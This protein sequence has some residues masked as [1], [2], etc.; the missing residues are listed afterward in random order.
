MEM[1][2]S[3]SDLRFLGL[4]E[5]KTKC[6][7]CNN[8][9][10]KYG[11]I[12]HGEGPV[13]EALFSCIKGVAEPSHRLPEAPAIQNGLSR[14]QLQYLAKYRIV[15]LA[16]DNTV[17]LGDFGL[18]KLMLSHE[19]ASTDVGTPSYMSPEI[20]AGKG[21]TLQSDV[22][23]LGCVMYE[24]CQKQPP[25]NGATRFE[26]NQRIQKGHY[27]PLPEVYS[28]DLRQLIADCLQ[29]DPSRRPETAALF[30][31][32][33]IRLLRRER[34]INALEQQLQR[35]RTIVMTRR[36]ELQQIAAHRIE[37]AAKMKEMV[38]AEVQARAEEDLKSTKF[39]IEVN[40]RVNARVNAELERQRMELE[41]KARVAGE[42]PPEHAIQS[43]LSFSC[44]Q[45][46][47][48]H[49]APEHSNGTILDPAFH[50]DILTCW[51]I[52]S[53][54]VLHDHQINVVR[55]SHALNSVALKSLHRPSEPSEHDRLSQ[56][57]IEDICSR[58]DLKISS[59]RQPAQSLPPLPTVNKKKLGEKVLTGQLDAAMIGPN[60][61]IPPTLPAFV[62]MP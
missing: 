33:I 54:T 51:K 47:K 6:I 46:I 55:L 44:L 56:A 9:A 1:C 22:W 19:F 26:L 53:S 20:Y 25:F 43:K 29:I 42:T 58:S 21:Y 39:E 59:V 61:S 3:P 40:A 60:S 49:L 12:W 11:G 37:D 62:F 27:P 45:L 32:P 30:N 35:E 5:E 48:M 7:L 17:K 31:L 18:S 34:K 14:V 50:C 10:L 2:H 28:K 52:F 4:L 15:F 24:L 23:A 41:V 8:Q 13:V 36:Q 16:S 38:E 57:H